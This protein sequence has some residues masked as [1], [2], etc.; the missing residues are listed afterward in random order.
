MDNSSFDPIAAVS[1]SQFMRRVDAFESQ[2]NSN[3]NKNIEL[4]HSKL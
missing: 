3:I 2:V 1:D 4:N